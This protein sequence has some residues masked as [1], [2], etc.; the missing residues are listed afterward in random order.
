MDTFNQYI[1]GIRG[2]DITILNPPPGSICKEDALVFA[3]WIVSLADPTGEEFKK[4]L[5]AVT[6]S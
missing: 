5:E 3:A 4:A 6:S 1:V 2:D